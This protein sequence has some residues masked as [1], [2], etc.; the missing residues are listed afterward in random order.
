MNCN[1]PETISQNCKIAR[2]QM[3]IQNRFDHIVRQQPQRMFVLK[4]EN[5]YAVI[6]CLIIIFCLSSRP[7]INFSI[8]HNQ[9]KNSIEIMAVHHDAFSQD[10]FS[11]QKSF[12]Y[13][14]V[15][16]GPVIMAKIFGV[17]GTKTCSFIKE[18]R[19]KNGPLVFR[20][21]LCS[22]HDEKLGN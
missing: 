17:F 11:R 10:F 12:H 3:R 18:N 7:E 21:V 2:I 14:I 5:V 13:T 19:T 4:P 6:T 1:N 16:G 20:T 9:H 15:D 8:V 22:K